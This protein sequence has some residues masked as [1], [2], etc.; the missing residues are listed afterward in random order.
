MHLIYNKSR[1]AF[2]FVFLLSVLCVGSNTKKSH[3]INQQS[4]LGDLTR[5]VTHSLILRTILM[6]I[7]VCF[8][9]ISVC[10]I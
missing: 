3:P 5:C 4:L 8:F 10:I 6:L 9:F 1:D 7:I 2:Y